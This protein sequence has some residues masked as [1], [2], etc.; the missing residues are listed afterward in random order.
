[1]RPLGVFYLTCGT[2]CLLVPWIS[3]TN[4]WPMA[5]V[6]GVGEWVGGFIFYQNRVPG[7]TVAGFLYS[8]DST[9]ERS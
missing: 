2:V 6:F 7:A 8:G 5:L 1:M 3:F 4:P 9:R